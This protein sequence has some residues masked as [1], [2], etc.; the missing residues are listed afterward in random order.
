MIK[1]DIKHLA[2]RFSELL[3]ERKNLDY[4]WAALADHFL[5]MRY[6]NI[7]DDLRIIENNSM[8]NS[9]L[10]DS[11]GIYAMRTLA[12]GMQG[13]MTSPA[14]PWFR[15]NIEDEDLT[16]WPAV[17]V[18][19]DKCAHAM[20][21]LLNR[22]NFYNSIH[23][24]YGNIA[25][26]GIGMLFEICDYKNGLRFYNIPMGQ[27]VVDIDHSGRVD[28]VFRRMQMTARQLVQEFG[29]NCPSRIKD[30]DKNQNAA[31][32]QR[33]DVIHA[34]YPRQES[35][36]NKLGQLNMPYASVF[37]L[38]GQGN[39]KHILRESGFEEF[40]A[41]V[42]RWDVLSGSAYG[43]SPA[44]D[45]LPDCKML[46]AMNTSLLKSIHKS[47]DPPM[48][49]SSSLKS[50]GLDLRPGG[51]NYTENMPGQAPQV[52]TPII[53]VRPDIQAARMAIETCQSQIKQ[54]LYN[55]LFRMLISSNRVNITAT[56]IAAKEEEKLILIG[57]VL[58]RLHDELFTPLID[59]TFNLMVRFDMLPPIPEELQGQAIKVEFVSLL[60]QAQKLISTSSVDKM[61]LFTGNLA[62]LFPEALDA[63]DADNV[64]DDYA[65]YLGVEVDMLR[66]RK[67]REEIREQRAAAAAEAK[68]ANAVE[69][70]LSMIK[71]LSKV[72]LDA[73]GGNVMQALSGG[74]GQ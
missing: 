23:C 51:L 39:N 71:D 7:G 14:R 1:T 21:N 2:G 11:T 36:A 19:L 67:A 40:P 56:E 26:F 64:I 52:A 66:S 43:R 31:S 49:V 35:R 30:I 60:A 8:L 24:L 20:R 34:I 6:H 9:K 45:C 25:T 69:K 33:W 55:D 38:E 18:F 58:E 59:R 28:T 57:P 61:M 32:S 22:S 4:A 41:F 10:V 65:E 5:P 44:M 27:F 3:Q 72:P 29:T 54:G 16:Q 13:G 37:W 46:Q 17:R 48:S 74:I 47:I 70:G 62:R 50:T 15:L 68:Q 42:P 12:S 73:K 63:I 53:N